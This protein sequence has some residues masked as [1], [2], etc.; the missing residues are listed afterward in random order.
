MRKIL[1]AIALSTLVTA[2]HADPYRLYQP[3][4]QPFRMPTQR[5]D[6][7][8]RQTQRDMDRALNRRYQ[9]DAMR[10]NQQQQLNYLNSTQWRG[11]QRYQW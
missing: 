7:L 1:I 3:H 8:Q 9:Q 4:V 5:V 10:W 6:Q 2:A 11:W